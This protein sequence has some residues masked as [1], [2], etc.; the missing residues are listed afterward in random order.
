TP[1]RRKDGS[2]RTIAT[3]AT[4][5]KTLVVV[6]PARAPPYSATKQPSGSRSRQRRQSA[7]VW[8][9]P[10]CRLR[11]RHRGRPAGSTGPTRS[12]ASPLPGGGSSGV[13]EGV[14]ALPPG[15][16][17]PARGAFG[18]A[19]GGQGRGRLRLGGQAEQLLQLPPAAA[20][21]LDRLTVED[22]GLERVGA[23]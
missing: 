18:L 4:G 23:L 9:Q 6:V 7:S 11:P 20:R 19:R 16:C 22:E 10:A 15:A 3:Q 2:T 21:A 13:Y 5:P 8:F 12:M 14:L 17:G 1:R